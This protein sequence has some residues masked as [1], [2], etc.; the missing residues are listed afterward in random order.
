MRASLCRETPLEDTGRQ[1][2]K[3]MR[4]FTC[5]VLSVACLL[6][7]GCSEEGRSPMT[8]KPLL[9]PGRAIDLIRI[10]EAVWAR[11]AALGIDA[12]SPAERVFLFVWNLE[13]EV[14]NGGF[15]QFFISSAGDNAAETPVALRAIGA[16]QAAAVAEEANRVFLP[17]GPSA[18][19]D[20]RTA[21]LE[22]LG[23]SATTALEALD[24]KFY[25]YPD[26]L[27]ELL[28]RFVDT[29]RDQFHEAR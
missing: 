15:E 1:R 9:P 14:N 13:A 23:K 12:L 28:R 29:N 6:T 19:R 5:T 21:A 17:T 2:L 4:S 25:K 8:G 22:R 18:D 26:N 20:A 24:A 16:L 3:K 7:A 11:E 27:E 10:S